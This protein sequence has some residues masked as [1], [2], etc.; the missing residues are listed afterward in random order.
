M[1][2]NQLK[3]LLEHF[4]SCREA[5]MALYRRLELNSDAERVRMLLAHLQH[6]ERENAEH[7]QD[8]ISQAKPELLETWTD[9]RVEK[10]LLDYMAKLSQPA[11]ISSDDVSNLAL[12]L[13]EQSL[14]LLRLAKDELTM[15]GARQFLAN[16]IEHQEKRQQQMVHATHRLDDI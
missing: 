1:R 11:D 14:S 4:V 5:M 9:I 15:L 3:L 2:F 13:S 8:F 16:L 7:L 6:Q 10:D 12:E